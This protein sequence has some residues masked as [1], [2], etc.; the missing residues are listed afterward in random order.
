MKAESSTIK[1]RNF[2][3]AAGAIARLRHGNNR[4]RRLRS[5]ELFDRR[6]QLIFLHRLGQESGGAFFYCA[7]AVL[8]ASAPNSDPDWNAPH[9]PALAPLPPAVLARHA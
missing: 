6:A 5:Y 4:A 2:L 1:T 8:G 7:I 9:C 3:L